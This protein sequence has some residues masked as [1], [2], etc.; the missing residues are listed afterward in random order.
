MSIDYVRLPVFMLVFFFICVV[1]DDA[2]AGKTISFLRFILRAFMLRRTKLQLI[3]S[4]TLVLP[5]LSEI[6]V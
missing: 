5:P 3:E 2:R 6:T 4:G 1:A